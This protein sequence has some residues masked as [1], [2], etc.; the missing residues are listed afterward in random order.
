[1]TMAWQV[2][3]AIMTKPNVNLFIVTYSI[4]LRCKIICLRNPVNKQI[5][6]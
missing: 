3:G 1:M 2:P 6:A 4:I 5:D